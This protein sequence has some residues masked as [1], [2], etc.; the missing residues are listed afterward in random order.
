M[1]ILSIVKVQWCNII[2]YLKISIM[3]FLRYLIG[4]GRYLRFSLISVVDFYYVINKLIILISD[5]H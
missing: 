2:Y 1:I 5:P 3:I 4:N